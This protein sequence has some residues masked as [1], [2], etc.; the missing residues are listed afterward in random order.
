MPIDFTKLL[1]LD[2]ATGTQLMKRGMPSGV[3]VEEWIIQ[4]PAVL[5]AVQQDYIKNGSMAVYAPTFAA[6]R[7]KLK[8]SSLKNDIY[9]TNMALLNISKEAVGGNALIGGNLSPTGELLSPLGSLTETELI[10][11]YKEQAQAFYDF[12]VDF[13]IIETMMDIREVKCAILACHDVYKTKKPTIFVTI[14]LEKN[15]KM[16]TG[17]DPLTALLIAQFYGADAFGLNCSSGPDHMLEIF[18]NEL[19]SYA[20]IP[21]IAKPNAGM[22]IETE[23]GTI[24][25]MPANEFADHMKKLTEAGI[26]V[27]GGCCGTTPEYIRGLTNLTKSEAASEKF[28]FISSVRKSARINE[29]TDISEINITNESDATDIY[30]EILDCESE[31]VQLNISC[32]NS[33]LSDLLEQLNMTVF[34]PIIFNTANENQKEFIKRIYTY[35]E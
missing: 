2:G 21:L 15:G 9:G 7:I 5:K 11:V 3:C 27:I 1:I 25:S 32:D 29:T 33:I 28:N 24:F 18:S 13:I 19:L 26:S 8:N 17:T 22:P 34:T 16:L 35:A 12:D 14:T 20:K 30:Y 10:E 23:T 4:N 31:V 6:N